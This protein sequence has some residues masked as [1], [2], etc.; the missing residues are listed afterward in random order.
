MF[1]PVSDHRK[2]ILQTTPR[3]GWVRSG[4]SR[5]ESIADH[6][7]RMSVLA[8]TMAGTQYDHQRLVKMAIVHDI[9]EAIV[10]DIAPSDNVTKEDKHAREAAAMETIG[11]LLG[12][13]TAAAKEI[14]ELWSAPCSMLSCSVVPLHVRL[15][16]RYCGPS[17]LSLPLNGY[18]VS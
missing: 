15:T 17:E 13:D 12:K 1:V 5:P 2:P 14:S 7:Y 8:L 6:M 18:I 10:G 3:T 9:A 4:V 16:C 11:D